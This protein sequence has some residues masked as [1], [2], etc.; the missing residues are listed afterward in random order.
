VVVTG[1]PVRVRLGVGAS[2]IPAAL[3]DDIVWISWPFL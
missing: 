3:A 2:D 1:G